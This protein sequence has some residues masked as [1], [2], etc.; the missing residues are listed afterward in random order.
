MDD[1]IFIYLFNKLPTPFFT[2]SLDFWGELT[3][4]DEL[5]FKRKLFLFLKEN[6]YYVMDMRFNITLEDLDE[7]EAFDHYY[8]G[9]FDLTATR[10]RFQYSSLDNTSIKT[11]G[12]F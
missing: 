10:A 3:C 12:K 11:I 6:P 4:Q 5:G 7:E 8:E 9:D 2:D 1:F